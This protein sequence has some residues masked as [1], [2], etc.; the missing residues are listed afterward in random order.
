MIDYGKHNV[1]GVSIDAVDYDA[2]VEQIVGAA[3]SR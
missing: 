2:I 1:L 3:K